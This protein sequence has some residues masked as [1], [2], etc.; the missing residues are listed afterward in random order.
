[1][2]A[3]ANPKTVLTATPWAWWKRWWNQQTPLG[4]DR[5]ANLAPLA[6][7]ALFLA[8]IV[9]SFW[10]LRNEEIR[11]EQESV[12]RDVDYAEQ[13]MRL[14]MLE[15]QGQVMQLSRGLALR[16]IRAEQFDQKAQQLIELYPEIQSLT[17]IDGQRRIMASQSTFSLM[18]RNS[19]SVGSHLNISETDNNYSLVKEFRQPIYAMVKTRPSSQGM[20]PSLQ[21]LGPM[22]DKNNRFHGVVL[23]EYT[24]DNLL[25]YG[26]PADVLSKYAVSLLGDGKRVLAGQSIPQREDLADRIPLWKRRS[27]LSLIHI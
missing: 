1:M 16:E 6:A 5:F 3:A 8:A 10:Y 26:V 21:L 25:R 18:L 11:R 14:R 27:N 13:R 17:W 22:I 20:T 2:S 12:K 15:A 24:L 9:I 4:Q 19:Y 7:V 23:A